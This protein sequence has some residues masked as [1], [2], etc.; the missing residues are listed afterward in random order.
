[1]DSSSDVATIGHR[2]CPGVTDQA[3]MQEPDCSD[4]E[5]SAFLV[6]LY[7]IVYVSTA[8]RELSLGEL[9][10]LQER[11]QVR[12]VREQVT[13]I[14]LFSEGS[15]MQYLEG[16]AEGLASVYGFIK[17][18]P[19]HYGIVDLV[20]E[21][22]RERE[23]SDW[24]MAFRVVGAMGQSSETSQD[25]ALMRCLLSTDEPVSA[26]RQQL[27]RFWNRGRSSVASTLDQFSSERARRVRQAR[28][29]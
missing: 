18:D 5:P 29:K 9:R 22:I 19:H 1:M 21:P 23:F 17:A 15:F 20:R 4:T 26:A 24:A 28:A 7:A 16:P 6:P 2:A 12:N 11:A 13:G 8:A 27:L 14:L 3:D 25:E 10:H